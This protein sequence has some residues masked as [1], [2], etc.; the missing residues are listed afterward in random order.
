MKRVTILAVFV[1]AFFVSGRVYGAT[2]FH[3]TSS[4]PAFHG[5]GGDPGDDNFHGT[6]GDPGDDNFHGTGGD[7]GDDN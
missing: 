1:L 3:G 7:P 4:T 5:T 6:G 2:T